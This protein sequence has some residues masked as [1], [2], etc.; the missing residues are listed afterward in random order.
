MKVPEEDTDSKDPH[1]MI[2]VSDGNP[3]KIL[4]HKAVMEASSLDMSPEE[5]NEYMSPF[6]TL[7]GTVFKKEV[8]D[9]RMTT[10]T[11]FGN[12]KLAKKGEHMK[13]ILPGLIDLDVDNMAKELGGV[14]LRECEAKKNSR[15]RMKTSNIELINTRYGD[16]KA[17]RNGKRFVSWRFMVHELLLSEHFR[18]PISVVRQPILYGYLAL[19]LAGKDRQAHWEELL[20]EFYGYLK[21]ELKEAYRQYFPIGAFMIVAVVGPFFEM[22][23]K[24]SDEETK[25]KGMDIVMEKTERAQNAVSILAEV[26][27]LNLYTPAGGLYGTHVTWEDVEEDMQRELDTVATFGPNKT[28][29][30]IGDGNILTQLAMQKISAEM[31]EM[32]NCHNAEVRTYNHLMKVPEGKIQIP[33]ILLHEN[34]TEWNPV[35]G[36]II[37]EYLDNLKAVHFYENV[38]TKEVKQIL[39]HKAVMEASS[40]DMSPEERNEYISPFKTLFGTV[41]KKENDD[42]HTTF[43]NGKLAKKGEHMKEIPAGLYRLDVDNMAEELGMENVLCHGD[44]WSMNVLWR[45]NGGALNMAAIVDY[46]RAH[47][48]CAATDLVR[49]FGACLAGKDRKL[50]GRNSWKSF[51][52]YLKEEVGD[53]KMPYTLEQL[54]EAYRQ[55]FPIGAF[56]IV[57]VVGPFFEMVCKNSDEETKKKG[58]DIVMEKTE[59][60]MDDIVYFHDRNIKLRKGKA[61]FMSKMVLVDPDWQHKDKQLPE[62]FVVK[63]LTQLAMQK[64]TAEMSEMHNTENSFSDPKFKAQLEALQKICHNAE[65][66]TYNHL[67][68]VPE[69]KIQIPKIYYMKM[70]TEWN[71]V[72]DQMMTLFTTFGDGKLA[73]KGEHY[74]GNPPGPCRS[75]LG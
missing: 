15:N 31:S 36:Y 8:L 56:M 46:Q 5:R 35:K 60:L 37:M 12:G 18:E 28:A 38:T 13:E 42:I 40:L 71:P 43:G 39:R 44:L 29:K 58:M 25:K 51:Y 7:F 19:V 57:A 4:R 3:A 26:M 55:Y 48:G 27:S 32:H 59:C 9:Q 47:F 62:K 22:V 34:V 72:L 1:Y 10:F 17:F 73:K 24:T 68:K 66:R 23:C 11:T 49:I 30:D 14:L 70:F 16:G 52:G 53:R 54:K 41:F 20:E 74:E 21:E 63:I 6:K 2:N 50:I 75:R 45:Q 33:K 61:G 67:M 69:G 64:V 65:V